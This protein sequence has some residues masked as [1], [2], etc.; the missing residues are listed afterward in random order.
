M[1]YRRTRNP[2]IAFVSSDDV[3]A[4]L[5]ELSELSGETKASLVGAMLEDLVPVYRGQIEAMRKIAN[6]PQDA[7]EHIRDLANQA[8]TT[9]AQAVLDLDKP[10][11]PRKRKGALS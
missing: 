7:Q 5:I 10:K 9:I 3:A 4:L 2:R 6:R 1:T 11:Q 8:S